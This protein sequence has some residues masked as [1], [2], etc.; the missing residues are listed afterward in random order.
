MRTTKTQK[1]EF[2]S[3]AMLGL[4]VGMYAKHLISLAEL[5]REEILSI[6]DRAEYWASQSDDELPESLKSLNKPIVC[7][8]FFEPSTRTRFSFEVAAK[9]LNLHVLN[10]D[11]K[12]S[13]SQKGETFY[14]TIRTLESMGVGIAIVRSSEEYLLSEIADKIK[15]TSLINAGAGISEHPTQA[16]LDLMTIKKEFGSFG[17]LKVS[18][19]GDV[20]HSRVARSSL[21]ALQ[22][23][24]ANVSLCGPDVFIP[25]ANA[26]PFKMKVLNIEEALSTADVVMLLRIQNE[27]HNISLGHYRDQF[28]L[29]SARL[30]L[31]QAHTKIMHPA[32]FNRGVEIDDELIES[33]R[34]LI[35]KQVAN[36]VAVRMAVLERAIR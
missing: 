30:A 35:F 14:D 25:D 1:L 15:T 6:L 20:K 33:D 29:T 16:L 22:R 4:F 10:F 21:H 24:G 11:Y 19:I 32:P 9:K 2:G 5:S 8:L 36:G 12:S 18:I 7:N 27:R 17:G 31:M 28:G 23:F 3:S 34:S 26:F 13:S